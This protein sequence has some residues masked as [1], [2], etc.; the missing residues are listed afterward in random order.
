MIFSK[1]KKP[2]EPGL[3]WFDFQDEG[4]PV[5]PVRVIRAI[6]G[7]LRMEWIGSGVEHPFIDSLGI[8]GDRIEIPTV[9]AAMSGKDGA[10]E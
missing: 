5:E 1:D 2:T 6:S 8:W 7:D 4:W 10:N 3:Y 9:E